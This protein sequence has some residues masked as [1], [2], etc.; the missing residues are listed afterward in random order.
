MLPAEGNLGKQEKIRTPKMDSRVAASLDC[1]SDGDGT[2]SHGSQ[3]LV[4]S[5]RLCNKVGYSS[6]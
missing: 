6:K 5:H 2:G 3:G 1:S 4:L